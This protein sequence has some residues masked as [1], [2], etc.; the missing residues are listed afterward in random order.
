MYIY[1][2]SPDRRGVRSVPSIRWLSL[3]YLSTWYDEPPASQPLC[4]CQCQELDADPPELQ[5]PNYSK[6]AQLMHSHVHQVWASPSG[7]VLCA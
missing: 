4:H 7:G 1:E 3:F 6:S 2:R 5:H